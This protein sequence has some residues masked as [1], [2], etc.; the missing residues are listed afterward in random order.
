[1][2]CILKWLPEILI[3]YLTFLAV[4]ILIVLCLGCG[5]RL[6]G[7]EDRSS[8]CKISV[9]AFVAEWCAPCKRAMPALI[10][11]RASGVQVTIIDV[12]KQP[13]IAKRYGVSSV[14]TFLVRTK[15]TTIRT[16]NIA[17]VQRLTE[18][19]K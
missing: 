3:A 10:A 18:A 11:I 19:C 15:D 4:V 1:M 8:K 9:I 2:K 16:Q 13:D 12:D 17:T 7:G 6:N 5:S 14:P